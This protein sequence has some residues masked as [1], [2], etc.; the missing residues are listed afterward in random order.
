MCPCTHSMEDEQPALVVQV[1]A[2]FDQL[3]FG[4]FWSCLL[5]KVISMASLLS[6]ARDTSK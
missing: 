5:M 2:L 3:G 4:Y 6:E 1:Q